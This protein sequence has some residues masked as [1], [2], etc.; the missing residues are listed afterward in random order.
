MS[1]SQ[2]SQAIHQLRAQ[3]V[4]DHQ[5]MRLVEATVTQH[6]EVIDDT[7]MKATQLKA[8]KANTGAGQLPPHR[9]RLHASSPSPWTRQQFLKWKP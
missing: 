5:W 8:D 9:Q 4:L 1:A 3:A 7:R 6:A 2:M